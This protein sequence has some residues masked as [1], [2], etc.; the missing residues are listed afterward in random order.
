M[1]LPVISPVAARQLMA[2]GALLVDIRGAGEHARE[3]IG[4]ARHLPM[5]QLLNGAG[6]ENAP[7]V[8][9]H[10]R[11][12]NRTLLNAGALAACADCQAYILEGGLDAWKKAGLPV[13][14]D[15]TQPMELQRQVQI[16]AGAM[17]LLGT[18]LGT[19][20]APGFYLI[21]GFIG[22]GLIFAGLSGFC[23]LARLL[24]KMPW[25]RRASKA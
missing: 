20:V 6:I 18:L 10:C 2:K 15:A 9:F 8:I 3:H 16:A 7:A 14:L 13:V 5:E 21:P 24:M 25:N 23:G 1:S 11:S 17:I 12:G 19:F 4:E 22:C